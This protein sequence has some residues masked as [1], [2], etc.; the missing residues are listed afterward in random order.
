[1]GKLTTYRLMAKQTVNT[2]VKAL[3][4]VQPDRKF[5]KCKTGEMLLAGWVPGDGVSSIMR[6]HTEVAMETPFDLDDDTANY[7]PTA[8]GAFTGE[9]LSMIA[10]D[11]RRNLRTKLCPDHPYIAVQVV[12]AVRY[13]AAKT[14]EDV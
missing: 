7:L 8:Y 4:S 10:Q 13:E 12:Y 5:G 2:V 6:M 1:G 11:R 9:L 14:I 3:A